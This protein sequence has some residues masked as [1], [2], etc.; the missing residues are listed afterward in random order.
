MEY[1]VAMN[2]ARS[3]S[4]EPRLATSEPAGTGFRTLFD[5][6]LGGFVADGATSSTAG[7]G[8]LAVTLAPLEFKI[9]EAQAPLRAGAAPSIAITGS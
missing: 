4:A 2:N 1:L 6:A 3:S 8:T 5:S 9:L 7:E